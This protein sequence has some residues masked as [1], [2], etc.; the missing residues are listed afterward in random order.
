MEKSTPVAAASAA[1]VAKTR[2]HMPAG[3]S[4]AVL[5]PVIA[6][7]AAC[8]FFATQS[9]RFLTGGN[10]SL[11]VQQVAVVGVIAIGQTLVILTAGIDLSCGMVMALASMVMTKLAADFGMGALPAILCGLAVT[12]LFGLINGLLVT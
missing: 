10:M 6:L 3:L 9:D 2:G 5:G 1:P 8:I 11:I 4:V 12:S 7:L